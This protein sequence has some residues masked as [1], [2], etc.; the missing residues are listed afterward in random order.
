MNKIFKELIGN[1]VQV[2]LDDLII[3]AETIEE[4]DILI[5]K[6]FD[7]LQENNSRIN[8][9]KVQYVMQ[10]VKILGILNGKN[11]IPNEIKKDIALSFPKPTGYGELRQFLGLVGL[12][13]F[14]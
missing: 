2:Y 5:R 4:H 7:L 14:C 12:E 6:A 1:G 8:V 9:K 13:N 10:E 3:Y 11:K